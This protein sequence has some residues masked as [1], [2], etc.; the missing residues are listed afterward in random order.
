MDAER[1]IEFILQM[2]A[3]AETEMAEMRQ[4]QAKAEA[5]AQRE[6]AAIRTLIRSGVKMLARNEELVKE[7][8][9]AQKDLAKAQKVTETKLQAFLD[10]MRRGRNGNHHKN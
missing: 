3:K 9:A 5:K 7:V 6:M 8:A 2:Q 1:T 4:H 10:S